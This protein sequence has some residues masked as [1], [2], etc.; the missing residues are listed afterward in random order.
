MTQTDP[1]QLALLA[2]SWLG[3]GLAHSLLAGATLERLF[4]SYRRVAFNCIAVVMT[5]LPLTIGASLPSVLLWEDP[6]WL[7]WAKGGVSMVA[8]LAFIHTL[9]FYSLPAFLGWTNETWPLIFSPWHRCVRHPWY[10]L[11]LVLIWMQTMTE[12]WLVSASC[13]TLYLIFGSRIEE[14]RILRH[15]PGS[16]A[17]YCRIVPGLI[18]WRGRALDEIT[19]LRLESQALTES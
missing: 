7:H 17:E 4:G 11:M 15:H 14:Q 2:A 19:R 12:T 18:P 9:Q 10:F 3:F 8:V 5:A 16:Y 6:L 13:M 1:R